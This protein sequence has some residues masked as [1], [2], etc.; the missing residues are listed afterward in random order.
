MSLSKLAKSELLSVPLVVFCLISIL[1]CIYVLKKCNRILNHLKKYDRSIQQII[2][3]ET[4]FY[5]TTVD[6]LYNVAL[7]IA[8]LPFAL[9]NV[10]QNKQG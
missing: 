9:Y 8:W 3:M 4:L 1:L 7:F 2:F 5:V 10:L 6:I